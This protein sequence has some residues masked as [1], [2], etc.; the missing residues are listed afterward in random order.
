MRDGEFPIPAAEMLLEEGMDFWL[1]G[2]S[3]WH[4]AVDLRV[5][6]FSE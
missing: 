2:L 6:G 4:D 1:M 3:I 5:L